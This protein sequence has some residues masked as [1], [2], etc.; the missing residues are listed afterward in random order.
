MAKRTHR[1]RQVTLPMAT[2][3]GIGAPILMEKDNMLAGNWNTVATN[4]A[5]KFTGFNFSTGQWDPKGLMYGAVPAVAG[6]M[7]SK[8]IGGNL[9]VNRKLASAG[10]PLLRL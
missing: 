3:L 9:G 5:W 1:R 6:V 8:F 10:V 2:L 7:I 4:L